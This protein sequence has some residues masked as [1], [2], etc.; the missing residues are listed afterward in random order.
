MGGIGQVLVSVYQAF[1]MP[2]IYLSVTLSFYICW[3]RAVLDLYNCR[4][5]EKRSVGITLAPVSPV[6]I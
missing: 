1:L 3:S 6:S 4:G 5:K 2:V